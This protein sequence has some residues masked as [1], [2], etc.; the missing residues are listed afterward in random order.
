MTNF[1]CRSDACRL[2]LETLDKL[3]L[4]LI[5]DLERAFAAAATIELAWWHKRAGAAP[6]SRRRL[7]NGKGSFGWRFFCQCG[8]DRAHG[9]FTAV[10]V[11]SADAEQNFNFALSEAVGTPDVKVTQKA[12]GIARRGHGQ[13]ESVLMFADRIGGPVV[14]A[15]EE[16]EAWRAISIDLTELMI[17]SVAKLFAERNDEFRQ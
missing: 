17:S 6:Y 11:E 1:S 5:F 10:P 3:I 15:P 9:V 12:P 7:P 13:V 16:S 14:R 2:D 4:G 8:Q